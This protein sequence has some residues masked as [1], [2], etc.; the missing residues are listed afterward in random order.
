M[1]LNEHDCKITHEYDKNKC[2]LPRL[3]SG[4]LYDTFKNKQLN[5][6]GDFKEIMLYCLKNFINSIKKD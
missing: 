4:K 6:E 3:R 1:I 5:K 2:K